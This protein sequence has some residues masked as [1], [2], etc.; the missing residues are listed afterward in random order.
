MACFAS[1]ASFQVKWKIGPCEFSS[2]FFSIN[3]FPINQHHRHQPLP[4]PSYPSSFYHSTRCLFMYPPYLHCA[5]WQGSGSLELCD[6]RERLRNLSSVVPALRTC[7]VRK[8]RQIHAPGAR[9]QRS[10]RWI[11]SC[12]QRI[13]LQPAHRV[14]FHLVNRRSRADTRLYR[15]IT[16]ISAWTEP[17]CKNAD[18]RGSQ[19]FRFTRRF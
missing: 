16:T 4:T 17:G 11:H 18:N 8:V 13:H 12:W 5:D 9:S 2:F 15:S 7:R 1:V 10:T 19:T 3:T 6:I 14:R